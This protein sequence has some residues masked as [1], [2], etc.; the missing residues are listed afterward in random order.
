MIIEFIISVFLGIFNTIFGIISIPATPL[1]IS[2]AINQIL[3]YL[4]MPAAVARV[5]IGESFFDAL[6]STIV[7][8]FTAMITYRPALWL[9]NKIRGSGN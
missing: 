2:N 4:T 7:I 6:I 8:A 1:V 5:Y 9:Y 3:P